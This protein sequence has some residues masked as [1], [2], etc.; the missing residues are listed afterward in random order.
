M[1]SFFFLLFPLGYTFEFW[2]EK[3]KLRLLKNDFVT[4]HFLHG[5]VIRIWS[6]EWSILSWQCSVWN[7]V[8]SLPSL[9]YARMV[10]C[11]EFPCSVFRH[12][13]HIHA[14]HTWF[15]DSYYQWIYHSDLSISFSA[16]ADENAKAR[17][18]ALTCLSVC[19]SACKQLITKFSQMFAFIRKYSG[20]RGE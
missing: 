8:Q 7:C 13:L 15:W 1:L 19:L 5:K 12:S 10:P 14:G 17:L 11:I 6:W 9:V 2:R 16:L 18:S 20:F 4:G 3:Q